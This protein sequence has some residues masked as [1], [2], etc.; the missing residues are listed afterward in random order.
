MFVDTHAHIPVDKKHEFIDNAINSDVKVIINASEDLETSKTSILLSKEFPNVF[1]CIGVHPSNADDFDLN[2]IKKFVEL[3]ENNKVVAIGEIG[4]DYY[5]TKDNKEKQ[6]E[7]FKAFL[8]LASEYNLPVVV[9]SRD[10]INDTINILKEYDVKGVIHC[11]S[12]S[13]EVAREYLKLGFALGIGGVVTFKNSKLNEVVKKIPKEN[14]LL[15][16]DS[17]FLS[18]EPYRGKPNESKNIPIIAHCIA[19]NLGIDIKEVA[20]ITTANA[21]RIFDI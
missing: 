13:L 14:I 16:T 20:D 3:I 18:P 4:L 17:P 12:G 6:I 15:E 8:N 5:W 19:E 10:A 9:H 11:F 2:D 1:A 21:K 7:V